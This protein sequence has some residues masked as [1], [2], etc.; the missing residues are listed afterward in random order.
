MSVN[1]FNIV[2]QL[3]LHPNPRSVWTNSNC[4]DRK[5]ECV[6]L[7]DQDKNN[8]L[9]LREKG[10]AE[11]TSPALDKVLPIEKRLCLFYT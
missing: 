10:G 8:S 11:K 1:M 3:G 9:L 5:I 7:S 4:V 2:F 6:F